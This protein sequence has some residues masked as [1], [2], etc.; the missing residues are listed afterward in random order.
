MSVT[1]DKI[2]QRLYRLNHKNP[3]PVEDF[4]GVR[5]IDESKNLFFENNALN[6]I[7]GWEGLAEDTNVAY[8]SVLD[9]YELVLKH[10]TKN[11]KLE[12]TN[13]LIS[14]VSKVRDSNALM[15]SLKYRFGRIRNATGIGGN[16]GKATVRNSIMQSI[17][18]LQNTLTSGQLMHSSSAS[19]PSPEGPS[20]EECYNRLLSEA[21]DVYEC[22]RITRQYSNIHKRFN[23]DKL[24]L[25]S[26]QTDNNPYNLIYD[27]ASCV[28]TFKSSFKSKYNSALESVWYGLNKY[29]IAC[30]N[31]YIINAVTDYF[32]ISRGL[33]ESEIEDIKSVE[34]ITPVFDVRDFTIINYLDGEETM[35]S[36]IDRLDYINHAEE[37]GAEDF[38]SIS[39]EVSDLQESA[40]DRITGIKNDSSIDNPECV[41]AFLTDFKKECLT[42]IDSVANLASF[43]SMLEKMDNEYATRSLSK[44]LPQM[45]SLIRSVFI[46]GSDLHDISKCTDLINQMQKMFDSI[47]LSKD[48]YSFILNVYEAEIKIAES[49]KERIDDK[50]FNDRISK[51]IDT[52]NK[53]KDAVKTFIDNMKEDKVEEVSSEDEGDGL[54]E[55]AEIIMISQL[56]ES[57]CEDLIDPDVSLII[58]G[59]VAKLSNNT[60]D[61]LTDFS[62]TIPSIINKDSLAEC[63]TN[64]R[65]SLRRQPNNSMNE[66]IRID[67]LN[68]N[69]SRLQE[70]SRVYNTIS[71]PT[72][73]IAYL[74]CLNELKALNT[75]SNSKYFTEAM[76]F[77]NTLKLAANNLRRTAIKL[78]DKEK[79]ACNSIDM[80]VNQITK[81]MDK[82]MS[83]AERE[84]VVRGQIL[85]PASKCIKY[86]L[87][88][89]VAWAVNPAIAIIG[90]IGVF[91]TRKKATV[92]ERQMALDEIDIELK[93]CER[94]IRI[95]EEQN[96]MQKLRQCETIQRNL[97]R[98]QQRIRYK[99]K[100]DFRHADVSSVS[101]VG[102]TDVRGSND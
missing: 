6:Y 77:T 15:R 93:M 40:L 23:I 102:G 42:N 27:I 70:D 60:I 84:R 68:N 64:Y 31:S 12:A 45:L 36:T 9:A 51:Y 83:A 46:M 43:K 30:E 54:K 47:T 67:C 88:F 3:N 80:A 58:N 71:D 79:A 49:K 37:Y 57:L 5:L 99:M 22:D 38:K 61:A 48:E 39:D 29:H 78:T 91:F 32:V 50:E 87:A 26:M 75:D 69:I 24:I 96:E 2:N 44:Q 85:P 66:Y 101:N 65:D 94:Y 74:M 28:D 33:S 90:A 25:E 82:E 63:F 16:I 52:L 13:F 17:N 18:N 62:V 19:E 73:C 95:Y 53:N 34:H 100:V 8:E 21:T 41:A 4:K 14:E 81:S 86:A 59:N 55:A 35:D 72:G 97:Q 10:G 11:A 76:S 98:Q 56:M 20:V 89:A 7:K 92:R 1:I